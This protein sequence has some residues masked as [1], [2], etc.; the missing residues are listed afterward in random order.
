MRDCP[1]GPFRLCL[2]HT[3]D[4]MPWARAHHINLMLS[5]H[6]HGGQIR[7]PLVGSVLVPSIFSRRYDCGVFWEEPTLLHVGRG[8]A[9][10]HARSAT[11][12][13]PK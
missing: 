6:T 2:S 4:N 7:F 3:P 5:G 11:T 13:A 10:Q 8:L 1:E 12:A 9:G